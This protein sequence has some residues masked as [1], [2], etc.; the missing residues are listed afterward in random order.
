MSK[1]TKK[2]QPI[3]GNRLGRKNKVNEGA[4]YLFGKVQ[5]QAIPL[6]EAVLG[7]LMLD[8]EG[9]VTVMDIL[10]SDAFYVDAHKEIYKAILNLFEKSQPVD[11]LTVSEQLKKNGQLESIGGPHY[12]VELTN[13]V[14]SAANIEYH[15][16]IISEMF[17]KRELLHLSTK[18]IG[19]AYEDT[20]DVFDLLEMAEQGLFAITQNNLS[21]S[22]EELSGLS[23]MVVK[24][25]E[26]LSKKTDAFTGVPSGFTDLDKVTSG[27]QPSDLIIVAA[28]PGMGKTSLTL[29]LA[30]N[31]A[32]DYKKG[33][34][35]FS[36]EMGAVQLAQRIIAAEAEIN[37]KSL[38]NGQLQGHEW[39]QLQ[40]TI[41]R[42][43]DV[44]IYIDDTPAINIFELRAKC[45]R[46]KSS[47]NLEL[48][49]ID[50]LQLMTAGGDSGT[51]NREQEISMIS[52]SLKALAK[53]LSVPIIALSQLS[54][55][56]EARGGVKRP[57]LSDL[58]ESGAI[59]Q[60]ADIVTF[61]YRPEY[62]GLDVDEEGNSVAGMAEFIIAKH[63]NGP[64][65]TIKLRWIG[66]FAKF[67]DYQEINFENMPA[68]M[69]STPTSN[70]ITKPSKMND[71]D[72]GD[73]PF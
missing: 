12:L 24:R 64:T 70:A 42:M 15:A 26:E 35:I 45:R 72:I 21:K 20:S 52:R 19:E 32:M 56:V 58:R 47:S 46:L 3:T 30:R 53:E 22:F 55:Q 54:R 6:E 48:V 34:A 5:P 37:M 63:R 50:Y 71:D 33:V 23:A 69:V 40:K 59:E 2:I 61:I 41:E 73:V 49:I 25:V 44:P 27:W 43:S 13:K 11:L 51:K 29:A 65:D 17:I 62:Y 57:Q 31:A 67:T 36:L 10:V 18:I 38:R 8:K 39:V 60:D 66:E 1:E 9:L 68:G 16:R 14:S 7:A 4:N 28:R